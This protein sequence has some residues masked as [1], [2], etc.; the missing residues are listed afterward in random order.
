MNLKLDHQLNLM[1]V[2]EVKPV[3]REQVVD[4]IILIGKIKIGMR[5]VAFDFV[6]VSRLL[7]RLN[8]V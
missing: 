7:T 1:K 6:S 4:M 2:Y 3:Q 5:L 8:I